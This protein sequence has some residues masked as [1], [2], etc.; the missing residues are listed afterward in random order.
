M[1][2]SPRSLVT[3]VLECNIIIKDMELQSRYN[4]YFRTSTLGKI[5]KLLILQLEFK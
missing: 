4:V 1:E 5:M 3:N 2:E